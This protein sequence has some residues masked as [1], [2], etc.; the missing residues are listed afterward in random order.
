MSQAV[1]FQTRKK[2][3]EIDVRKKA[4]EERY[5]DELTKEKRGE[6]AESEAQ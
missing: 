3:K 4:A 1:L 6:G 5:E 2:K